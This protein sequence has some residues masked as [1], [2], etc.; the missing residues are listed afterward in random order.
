MVG[1]VG[2][3]AQV[4][5]VG[6]VAPPGDPD[7]EAEPPGGPELRP[8]A[9][10]VGGPLAASVHLITMS[11]GAHELTGGVLHVVAGGLWIVACDVDHAG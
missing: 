1:A 6:A 2:G 9:G 4:D 7:A 8:E 5:A 11:E 10:E 3:G